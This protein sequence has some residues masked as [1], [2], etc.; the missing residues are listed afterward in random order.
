MAI[1]V[2]ALNWFNPL[3][4]V[5]PTP[6]LFNLY[7][8]KNYT[9]K[10]LMKRWASNL[11]IH[12]PASNHA[13]NLFIKQKSSTFSF[14]LQANKQRWIRTFVLGDPGR[15]YWCPMIVVLP[16]GTNLDA[17]PSASKH[18]DFPESKMLNCSPKLT[19]NGISLCKSSKIKRMCTI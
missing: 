18:Y 5:Y 6:G 12:F 9:C 1:N 10:M 16:Q 11:T 7:T 4:V 14:Y 19:N 17:V 2:K 15:R 8:S 13:K 3:A